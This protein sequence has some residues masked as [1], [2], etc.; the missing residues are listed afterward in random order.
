MNEKGRNPTVGAGF[1]PAPKTVEDEPKKP[2]RKP[3]RLPGYDYGNAGMYFITIC[4]HGRRCLFGRIADGKMHL[5]ELGVIAET[6]WHDLAAHYPHVDLDSFV[7]MPN[8]VHGI[9]CLTH[10]A[11]AGD[12][13]ALRHGLPEVIR[14]FKTFSARRITSRRKASEPLW[15]RGYYEHI[16]RREDSLDNIR[17]Y[18]ET[19]PLRWHLDR[20]NPAAVRTV[21]GAG[22]KPA[23][24]DEVAAD[25]P[26]LPPFL[27]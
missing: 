15:Q 2:G 13:T 14:A 12:E 8:H 7:I 3:L 23:P 10:H 20:E 4:T 5:N 19:N 1:K 9:V 26:D 18:I 25:D 17:E 27:R 16:I 11:V 24:T 6:C 22:L 21:A